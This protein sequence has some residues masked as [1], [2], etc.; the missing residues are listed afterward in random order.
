MG[1]VSWVLP[2][3]GDVNDALATQQPPSRCV[4]R[5]T[6]RAVLPKPLA[7]VRCPTYC[8][9]IEAFA[10]ACPKCPRGRIA[11]DDCLLD[12]CVE[13]RREVARRRVDDL[14][15]LSSRSLLLQSLARLGD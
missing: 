13:H 5:G 14:Q 11:K 9:R 8:D 3:V 15:Y 10:V 1:S 4:G 6:C 7:Q 12:H 2:N